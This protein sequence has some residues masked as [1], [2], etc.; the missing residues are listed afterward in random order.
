MATILFLAAV[1]VAPVLA[2][3]WL[4][5]FLGRSAIGSRAAGLSGLSLVFA[6]TG[7]AHFAQTESMAQMLP[8]WVPG[9]IP[10]IYATGVLELAA[11]VGLQV[12]RLVRATGIC[13]LVFLIL[14]FPANIYSAIHQ[15]DF[16]GHAAGPVYLL[17]RAPL[18]ALLLGW[19][20][21]FA[22]R[23]SESSL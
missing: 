23:K 15:V 14:A 10:I 4:N 3:G 11:A 7:L 1:L 21:W 18:Q 16:G 6:I 17:A 9:R 2:R 22:V 20:W 12:S 5:R 19:T 8:P 13:L